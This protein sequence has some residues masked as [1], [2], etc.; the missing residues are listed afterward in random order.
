MISASFIEAYPADNTLKLDVKEY[1][2][3]NGLK[4]LILEKHDA[5]VISLRIVYKVGSANERPGITGVSHL[6]EHMMFKGSKIFG[7]KDYGAEKPLLEKEEQLVTTLMTL[8]NDEAQMAQGLTSNQLKEDQQKEKLQ[9]KIEKVENE[10]A[11]VRNQLKELTISEEIWSI[12]PQHGAKGLNASTSSDLTTYYCDLPA[13]KLELWAFIES[14][15]MKNMVLREF[16]SERDVVMEERRLRTETDP[17][18]LLMEQLDAASFT[19]HPYGWPTVG[20]MS[21]L[22]NLTKEETSEYFKKYYTPNNAVLVIVGDVNANSA[23]KLI[24]KYFGNIPGQPPP[25]PVKTVEPEQV[26]ERRIY[27]EY[28]ANPQLAIAYHKPAIGHP[29]QYVF[30]V[31]EGLLSSGRTS[32]LYKGLIEE[33]RIAVSANAYGGASKYP[34]SFLFFVTPRYPHTVE[35]DEASLYE[36]I[37]KIKTMPVDDWELQKI[38]NQIQA[39]FIRNMESSS[40]LASMI[41]YYEGIYSWRYINSYVDRAIAVTK[42]DIMRVAKRYFT[43]TNRTVAILI[44][45]EDG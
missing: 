20:W 31:I 18:G 7:T 42:E 34:D 21:D 22:K 41:A 17:T 2:L 3:K 14:D 36:E 8:K 6:F 39:D 19:A 27:V 45:K 9:K 37:E 13:N 40:G 44:K 26:G 25:P 30:D 43:K 32:R 1:L 24:E 23:I 28:D 12:Y 29:D 33:K 10:L 15:R 4:V 16:Y 11:V 38:K 5:P 35:E